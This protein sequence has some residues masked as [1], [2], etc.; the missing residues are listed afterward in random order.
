ME[1]KKKPQPCRPLRKGREEA[2]AHQEPV[3]R[4]SPTAWAKLVYFRDRGRT[5][6]GGFGITP[7]DDLLCIEEF[8]T[9]QQQVSAATVAFD[10]EAVADFFEGQVDAGRK[11]EQFARLWLHTHPGFSPEPS[12]VDK[13]T[14]NRVFGGC[15]WAMMFVLGKSD[16]TH[17]QLRFNVGP[18]GEASIPVAVDYARDFGPSDRKA[19]E[20]E[21]QANIHPLK[22]SLWLGWDDDDWDETDRA[23]CSVPEEWRQELEAMDPDER[24]LILTELGLEPKE[25]DEETQEVLL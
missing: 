10:D 24:R 25:G 19:W 11:P 20:S 21:Y 1:Q 13:E 23:G 17:A 15:Q 3:L 12:A 18:G 5:E 16:K 8:M 22:R 2:T 14:F 7:P 6:I 4:F 9:V